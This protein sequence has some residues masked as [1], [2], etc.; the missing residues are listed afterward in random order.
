M[1]NPGGVRALYVFS[2]GVMHDFVSIINR[3]DI[4]GLL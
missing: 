3:V 2:M 1:L 4:Q